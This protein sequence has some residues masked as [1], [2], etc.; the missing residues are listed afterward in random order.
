MPSCSN[1]DSSLRLIKVKLCRTLHECVDWNWSVPVRVAGYSGRTLHECVDWNKHLRYIKIEKFSRT[2]H[3]CVDWNKIETLKERIDLLSHSTRVRGLKYTFPNLFLKA[4]TS[5][6]TRVRG[7]KWP[8]PKTLNV[9][10]QVALYTSAW[11]E[12]KSQR[13]DTAAAVALYTSAW[14][15]ITH[16]QPP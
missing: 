9:M 8:I 13:V 3:E 14:I 7:L 4:F 5:H 16:V 6:S 2:L 1:F 10:I 12:I 11:I 15:E